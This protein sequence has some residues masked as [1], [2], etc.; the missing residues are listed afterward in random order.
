VM[1]DR[2]FYGTVAALTALSGGAMVLVLLL[3]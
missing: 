2:A 3:A 1:T